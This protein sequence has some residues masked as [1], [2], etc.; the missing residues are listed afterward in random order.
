MPILFLLIALF[1]PR[2]AIVLLW[3]FTTWFDGLFG[4]VFW[5]LIGFIF[6]P[7]SLLWY[8][9][10]QHFY[11]GQWTTVPIIGLVIAVLLDLSATRFRR[12]RAEP[13]AT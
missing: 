5:P 13:L 9:V 3:L 11:S 12:R 1:L 6:L 10:V 2:V 4:T 7:L 8:S